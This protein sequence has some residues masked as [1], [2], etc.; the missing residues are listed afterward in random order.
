MPRWRSGSASH[1][2]LRRV[3]FNEKVTRSIRVRGIR[4]R[5]LVFALCRTQ[6]HFFQSVWPINLHRSLIIGVDLS[7]VAAGSR[8]RGRVRHAMVGGNFAT[9]Y[10]RSK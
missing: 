4:G 9:G 2:Y 6:Q 5:Q 3:R 7:F 1:L 10:T 8:N